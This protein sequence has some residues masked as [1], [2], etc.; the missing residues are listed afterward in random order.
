MHL[1]KIKQIWEC[2]S[3]IYQNKLS[4]RPDQL[5]EFMVHMLLMSWNAFATPYLKEEALAEYS[6]HTLIGDCNEEY[7]C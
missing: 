4:M 7:K 1:K 6:I 2:I 5:K 3:V